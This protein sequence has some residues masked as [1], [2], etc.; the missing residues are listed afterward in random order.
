[1]LRLSLKNLKL[2]EILFTILLFNVARNAITSYLFFL[3]A[4]NHVQLKYSFNFLKF[5]CLANIYIYDIYLE[6]IVHR[7]QSDSKETKF[8]QLV[9]LMAEN[10]DRQQIIHSFN[11]SFFYRHAK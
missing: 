11:F 6:L 2:T 3:D 9:I 5:H 1:M 10:G 7:F 8:L 4:Y